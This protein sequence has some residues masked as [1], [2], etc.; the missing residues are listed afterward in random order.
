MASLAGYFEDFTS[1]IWKD[2]SPK[3]SAAILLLGGD[4]DEMEHRAGQILLA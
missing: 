2:C 3:S 4:I 1:H